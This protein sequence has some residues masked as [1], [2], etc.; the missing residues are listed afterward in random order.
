MLP[1]KGPL[2]AVALLGFL[3][4]ASAKQVLCDS[5]KSVAS[6][7]DYNATN[8]Y[9]NETINFSK[10]RGSLLAIINLVSLL[11]LCNLIELCIVNNI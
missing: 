3:A 5:S 7:Y 2:L 9:G 1:D 8:I 11:L 4:S 10:Y 6:I